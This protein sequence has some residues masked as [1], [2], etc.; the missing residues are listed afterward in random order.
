VGDRAALEATA[1]IPWGERRSYERLGV[2]GGGAYALGRAFGANPL[3]IVFPCH[4]VTCGS[5]FPDAYVGGPAARAWLSEFEGLRG[6][7]G[8]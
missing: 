8:S 5:R 7:A 2:D 4:R 6:A 3:P 1:A